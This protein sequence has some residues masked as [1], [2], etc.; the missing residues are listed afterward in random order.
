MSEALLQ[1]RFYKLLCRGL[2]P[3]LAGFV[4]LHLKTCMQSSVHVYE[5]CVSFSGRRRFRLCTSL[6]S[7][8]GC[9]LCS[10]L[11]LCSLSVLGSHPQKCPSLLVLSSVSE[12]IPLTVWAQF[13]ILRVY[14]SLLNS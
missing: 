4:I 2:Q 14:P 11:A 1:F 9:L 8:A 10:A 3:S 13:Y 7:H 6:A 12:E 5:H